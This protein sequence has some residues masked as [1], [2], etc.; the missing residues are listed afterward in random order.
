M[1]DHLEKAQ[2]ALAEAKDT[3]E[4]SRHRLALLDIAQV[5]AQVS[6]AASLDRIADCLDT[7]WPDAANRRADRG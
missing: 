4:G 1:C 3:E 5:Q 7:R 6:Q 2:A